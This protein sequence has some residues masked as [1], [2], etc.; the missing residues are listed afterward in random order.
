MSFSIRKNKASS[1]THHPSKAPIRARAPW[2]FSK[3]HSLPIKSE[4]TFPGLDQDAQPIYVAIH[5][6]KEGRGEAQIVC[7]IEVGP[8]LAHSAQEIGK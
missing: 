7:G 6:G 1:P 4:G 2:V 8:S 5:R 3:V